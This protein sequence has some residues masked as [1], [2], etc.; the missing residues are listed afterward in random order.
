[1]NLAGNSATLWHWSTVLERKTQTRGIALLIDTNNCEQRTAW[2]S[3]RENQ[4]ANR[5][6]SHHSLRPRP[7][8][9][10]GS[11]RTHFNVTSINTCAA[12]DSPLLTGRTTKIY[13]TLQNS[14]VHKGVE[15]F[16]HISPTC[17]MRPRLF[18]RFTAFSKIA[19]TCLAR[20]TKQ[21]TGHLF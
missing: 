12:E 8:C 21:R 10:R 13:K 18:R 9:L 2:S 20:I 19:R 7:C 4:R 15:P 11:F 1:M 3:T 5:L 16:W 14:L 17:Q 6:G